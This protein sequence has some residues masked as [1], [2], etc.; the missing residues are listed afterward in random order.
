M[1]Y[2]NKQS[3]NDKTL[4]VKRMW[5]FHSDA[6][7]LLDKNAELSTLNHKLHK[8]MGKVWYFRGE[9]TWGKVILD[10]DLTCHRDA[11]KWYLGE[12]SGIKING[13]DGNINKGIESLTTVRIIIIKNRGENKCC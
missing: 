2:N 1:T 11:K 5:E 12:K 9:K 3:D 13:Y 4:Q 6:T 7:V 10:K 8:E